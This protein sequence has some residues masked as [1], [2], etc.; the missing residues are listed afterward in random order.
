M[1]HD[2][3]PNYIQTLGRAMEIIH[4][5]QDDTYLSLSAIAAR[6]GMSTSATYRLLYTLCR[7]GLLAQAGSKKLYFL[8]DEAILIGIAGIRGRKIYKTSLPLIREYYTQSGQT[9]G[10]VALVGDSAVPIIQYS[11]MPDELD[12]ISPYQCVP[13]HRGASQR[14][15]LAFFPPERRQAYLDSLFLEETAKQNLAAELARIRERGWDCTEEQL[16]R[17][18]WTLSLPIF[19][20]SGAIAGDIYT[21]DYVSEMNPALQQERLSQLRRLAGRVQYQMALLD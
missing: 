11:S 9:V 15:L 19:Y 5:F 20:T 16:S 10:A 4:L 14:I 6:T 3:D 8:N 13:L 7:H 2:K 18:I 12:T 21:M 1:K 17:G